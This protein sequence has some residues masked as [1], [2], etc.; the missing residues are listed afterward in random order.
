MRRRHRPPDMD[1]PDGDG[2]AMLREAVAAAVGRHDADAVLLSGGLDSSAVAAFA[3]ADLAVTADFEGE[4]SDRRYARRVCEHLGLDWEPLGLSEAEATDVLADL[5]RRT[6][7]FDPGLYNDVPVYAA[8][9]RAAELGYGSVATGDAGDYLFLGYSFLWDRDDP[10][11]YVREVLDHVAFRS[12]EVGEWFGLTVAQPYLDDD[13]VEFALGIDP[14]RKVAERP[15]RDA[16]GDVA[17][18]DDADRRWGKLVLRE[19]MAG[20]LPDAVLDRPKT[21]LEYGSGV[22][23]LR[24]RIADRTDP[25]AVSDLEGEH[26][27][28]L[29]DASHAFLFETFLDE[30]GELPDD[31]GDGTCP[32]C[33]SERPPERSHCRVCGVTDDHLDGD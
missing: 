32:N 24:E 23:V 18:A 12:T 10:N 8:V 25:E 1:A 3:D 7:S 20:V 9:E 30:V 22:A 2:P 11:E 26:D 28:L 5:V 29:L 33:G 14:A 4:G 16:P 31:R 21:D 27:L 6:G 17:V 15:D 13:L 19:A